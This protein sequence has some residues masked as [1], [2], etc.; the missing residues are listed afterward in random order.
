MTDQKSV[1]HKREDLWYISDNDVIT[2]SFV[3][4]SLPHTQEQ[5]AMKKNS[6]KTK[7][8]TSLRLESKTLKALKMK[9]IRE[10]TSVQKIVEKLITDYL[11]K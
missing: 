8:N 4:E 7:K 2:S 10:D 3:L 6:G 5:T 9:A 11:K 1:V